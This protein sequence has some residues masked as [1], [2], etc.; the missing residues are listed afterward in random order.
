MDPQLLTLSK[1]FT[2]RLLR[3]PDY[4]RGYAWADKQLRDFWNDIQQLEPGRN[5]YTGV[6]TLESVPD[7]VVRQWDDDLW[8]V[9]AKSYQPFF[10]VDGQ[11]RLTTAI[12]LTQVILECIA[13]EQ[14]LNYTEKTDIQRKFIFDSKDNGI[15]RSYIF[16][17]EKDNPSYEFL[18]TKIFRE[19]S[20][21]GSSEETVYTHNLAQAKKFF[22]EHF[23]P[24]S[25]E[26]LEGLYRKVTQNLLFNIF[27]ITDDVDVCVAFETM[28]NRG[29]PLS[30]LELLKNRLI[31]LSLKFEAPDYERK[32]LRR[33]INDCWK[34]IYHKLG[35]NKESLLDDDKF[36]LTHYV[37]F[38]NTAVHDDLQAEGDLRYRR[39]LR[40]D[41]ARDLLENRFIAK[42]VAA[43]AAPDVRITLSDVY[44][45]VSSL[46]DA[47]E[48]W[49]KMYNPFDSDFSPDT[50]AWLDKLNRIGMDPFLPLILVFLQKVPVDSKRLAFL[51]TVESY[52]FVVSLLNRYYGAT[53]LPDMD[54][55]ALLSAIEMSTGKLSEDK[56]TPNIAETTTSILKQATS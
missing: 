41:Y 39:L 9:E 14:K 54:P 47:V 46:Q 45:Y 10:V 32:Q 40:A 48:T 6:L 51:H 25:L 38:Y 4:Q 8:I 21:A 16:G 43:D 37:I 53:Y 17:Y 27:T 18:K 56:V 29:K 5:H 3:I 26:E 2:E 24:L 28:N 23:A 44:Q 34:A 20:S 1:I 35:R 55:K 33:A 52:L 19:R 49:F 22:S 11:Q 36:L 15:S 31:Y 30:Y 13:P 42:N 12:I 7:P 50:K